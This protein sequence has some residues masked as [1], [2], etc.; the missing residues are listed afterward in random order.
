[1]S[2][3]S[4]QL[5]FLAMGGSIAPPLLLLTILFLGSERPLY[6]D[7]ALALGYLRGDGRISIVDPPGAAEELQ[8]I[9]Q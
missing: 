2:A 9:E 5:V 6:N 8:P 7:T 4:P 3:V 1:M